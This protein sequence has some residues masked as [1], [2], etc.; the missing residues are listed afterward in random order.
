M[1]L[2]SMSI[3]CGCMQAVSLCG[4]PCGGFFT[5]DL[6]PTF[7]AESQTCANAKI[8]NARNFSWPELYNIHQVS[9]TEFMWL[10]I[11]SILLG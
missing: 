7:L 1:T 2:T 5:S 11:W 9:A 8:S 6:E 4:Y 10:F 3:A